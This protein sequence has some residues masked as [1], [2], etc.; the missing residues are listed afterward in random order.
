MPLQTRI[1]AVGRMGSG[2]EVDLCGQYSARIKNTLE[3]VEIDDRKAPAKGRKAWEAE[4]IKA[5]IPP[6]GIIVA[7]DE[8]GR[9]MDSRAFASWTDGKWSYGETLVF[10]IGGPDGLDPEI[11]AKAHIKLAFGAMT[12]PHKLVRVLLLEQLYR[13]ETILTGHPYHRD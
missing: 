7:L 10:V 11:L 2:P 5:H 1:I 13:A 6:N 3:I 12:W 8:Q 9:T 4:R